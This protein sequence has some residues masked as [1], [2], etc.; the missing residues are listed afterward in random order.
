VGK[1]K[2]PGGTTAVT[3]GTDEETAAQQSVIDIRTAFIKAYC[4][5]QDW[6]EDVME[7]TIDQIL[8]IRDQ[9]GWKNAGRPVRK[10]A[11]A[12]ARG[13]P[14]LRGFIAHVHVEPVDDDMMKFTFDCACGETTR[15]RLKWEM[16]PAFV[17]CK[18]G[19]TFEIREG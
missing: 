3:F 18:C 1:L 6:P 16:L 19:A 11:E 12:E 15:C 2:I 5:E 13:M 8:Q 4:K 10:T 17:G 7:L 9:P 14:A